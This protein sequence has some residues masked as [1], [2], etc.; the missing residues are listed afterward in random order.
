MR[1]TVD[2][3]GPFTLLA[4]ASFLFLSCGGK[5]SAVDAAG[6]QA[7]R[8]EFLWWFFFWICG[9]V[10]VVVMAVLIAAIVR[11]QRADQNDA[12][13]IKP[14]AARE[15]KTANIV[16]AAVAITVITMFGLILLSFRT[17]REI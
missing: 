7:E 5:Q 4:L 16:K 12:P 13:D 10:Y 11:N 6:I 14:P 1:R 8:L 17:G 15:K 2:K 9:A 3:S